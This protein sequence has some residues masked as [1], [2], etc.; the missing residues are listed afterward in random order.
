MRNWPRKKTPWPSSW[1]TLSS[2]WN[3]RDADTKRTNARPEGHLRVSQASGNKLKP[4][5][6]PWS[7]SCRQTPRRKS[8]GEMKPAPCRRN[9]R[10][11]AAHKGL[12]VVLLSHRRPSNQHFTQLLGHQRPPATSC[13]AALR[14]RGLGTGRDAA[15]LLSA[16]ALWGR[17]SVL[18]STFSALQPLRWRWLKRTYSVFLCRTHMTHFSQCLSRINYWTI[19]SLN[20]SVTVFA[21]ACVLQSQLGKRLENKFFC[22]LLQVLLYIILNKSNGENSLESHTFSGHLHNYIQ[23]ESVKLG[24]SKDRSHSGLLFFHVT[25]VG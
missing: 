4:S 24:C 16:C 3:L 5:P 12:V 9:K 8:N 20:G 17:W 19:S 1:I 11:A 15:L 10:A 25:T 22:C 23:A 18:S 21:V 7:P 13:M 14:D 6:Q 2:G